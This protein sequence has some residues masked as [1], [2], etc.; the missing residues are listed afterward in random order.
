MRKRLF[1]FIVVPMIFILVACNGGAVQNAYDQTQDNEDKKVSNEPNDN[2]EG[3]NRTELLDISQLYWGMSI[4]EIEELFPAKKF[5]HNKS[6]DITSLTL[7]E[8]RFN[9]SV[10]VDG[11]SMHLSIDQSGLSA[12]YFTLNMNKACNKDNPDA[13]ELVNTGFEELYNKFIT[14]VD[15]TSTRQRSS[16]VEEWSNDHSEF[17][18]AF[19]VNL[20]ENPPIP[21]A[22]VMIKKNKENVAVVVKASAEIVENNNEDSWLGK[23]NRPLR[24]N[25]A[26]LNVLEM[27]DKG[28]TFTI[29]STWHARTGMVDGS[30]FFTSTSQAIFEDG[31]GCQISFVKNG[32]KMEVTQTMECSGYGGLNVTFEGD[33][34]KGDVQVPEASLLDIGIFETKKQDDLFRK[35]V[36][37][38]YNLFVENMGVYAL[39][40]N[41]D[42]FNANVVQ[43]YI[44]GLATLN[45]AI[46]MYNENNEIWGATLHDGQVLY[47][48]NVGEYKRNIP[49]T[50]KEWIQDVGGYNGK[51]MFKSK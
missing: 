27:N 50:I 39:G 3:N 15:P 47:Y 45:E 31:L 6:G 34:L 36:G 13:Q 38:D 41:L 4:Q 16:T 37:E 20:H 46:I 40:S 11:D 14:E 2:R 51:V 23:W 7:T 32:G 42:N 12:I 19:W 30:A 1:G 17:E 43:G 24:N 18:L 22:D 26:T 48:S 49:V 9:G 5:E 10:C 8:N 33:F 25:S 35:V 21:Y 28:F 44:V 29:S